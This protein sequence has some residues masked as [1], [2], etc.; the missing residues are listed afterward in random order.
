MVRCR[1]SPIYPDIAVLVCGDKIGDESP[2]VWLAKDHELDEVDKVELGGS[3][4][5][6]VAC[7]MAV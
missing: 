2:A 1:Q 4:G 5:V 3:A 6:G 7:Q